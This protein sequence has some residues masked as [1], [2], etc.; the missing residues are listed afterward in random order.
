ME[1]IFSASPENRF[2]HEEHS[3]LMSDMLTPASGFAVA[4]FLKKGRTTA[5]AQ[6]KARQS[7]VR[8]TNDGPRLA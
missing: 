3:T 1:R 8:Y 6:S 7:H 2:P 4:V 5:H